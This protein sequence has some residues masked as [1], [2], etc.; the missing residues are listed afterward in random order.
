MKANH[1]RRTKMHDESIFHR[2]LEK[3]T[4]QRAAFLDEA[5]HGDAELRRRVERLLAEHERPDRHIL[6]APPAGFNA[7][8]YRSRPSPWIGKVIGHY[9]LHQEIGAGGMGIVL[10]AEQTQPLQRMVALK[11]IKPGMDTAQVIARFEA[12]RQALAMM[13]HP[14]IAKVL[15]AGTTDNGQPYFVMELVK[16]VPITTYCDEQHLPLRKRLELFVQVCQAIQHAHHKGIIH[17]DLKPTNVLVAEYDDRAVPKV[18]DFGVAKATAQ[19]LTER[20]MFTEFGQL[21]GTF[22]YMSPEQAKLNQLDVDTRS[23]IYSL[24]VLLYEL[25]AGSTP[26][27]R[28]RLR[29]AAFDEIL[30]IIREEEP[31]KPSTRLSTTDQLPTIAANRGL[32]PKKLSG[33]VKR[34]LDWIVMKSLE[35]D[36]TRRY[37]TASSF[38]EDIQRYLVGEA[39]AAHPPGTLYRLRK[40]LVKRRR[41]VAVAGLILFALLAGVAGIVLGL[42][43]ANRETAQKLAAEQQALSALRSKSEAETL[44]S[45]I[46]QN[47]L[48]NE[49][50][51]RP[52]WPAG[53]IALAAKLG[54]THREPLAQALVSEALAG[55]DANCVKDFSPLAAEYCAWNLTGEQLAIGGGSGGDIRIWNRLTNEE[56]SLRGVGPIEFDAD[57]LPVQLRRCSQD[58][59]AAYELVDLGSGKVRHRLELPADEAGNIG[60]LYLARRARYVVV[61]GESIASK[62]TPSPCD[63]P[64]PAGHTFIWDGH[65]GALLHKLPRSLNCVAVSPDGK[66]LAGGDGD[67]H[68]TLWDLD[69]GAELASLQ[70]D[71]LPIR[72]LAFARDYFAPQAH[73]HGHPRWLLAAGDSGGNV[74]IWDLALQIPRSVCSGGHYDILALDFFPDSSLL[75]SGGRHEAKIWDV[76]SGRELFALPAADF[77]LQT[78]FSPRGHLA[79]CGL[80]HPARATVWNLDLGRGIKLLRGLRGQ[81]AKMAFSPDQTYVA[82]LTHDWTIGVWTTDGRLK[83]A[84]RAPRGQT[85]DNAALA[86][87]PNQ[88]QLAYAAGTSAVLYDLRT[89]TVARHWD[90]P[91]GLV[92]VMAFPAADKLLLYRFESAGILRNL[93]AENPVIASTGASPLGE[94]RPYSA[95]ISAD[96]ERLVID[97]LQLNKDRKRMVGVFDAVGQMCYQVPTTMTAPFASVGFDPQGKVLAVRVHHDESTAL[98]DA[99]DGRSR[100]ALKKFPSPLGPDQQLWVRRRQEDPACPGFDLLRVHPPEQPIPF[101]V[102]L[103]GS[104]AMCFSRDGKLL[105]WGNPDGAV[106]LCEIAAVQRELSK[107]GFE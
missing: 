50:S 24:G 72:S 36:R 30:R 68:I 6:D 74:A 5:C 84:I 101:R 42:A 71:R 32:E 70:R 91:A 104:M 95:A 67:G 61:S 4:G 26:I 90:L 100:G 10:M 60:A 16:G 88:E 85:A 79:L 82:A 63:E 43:R 29:D 54:R 18:I 15:D 27:L 23:D 8:E 3:P 103:A 38:A 62:A 106:S 48:E 86:F 21:L 65:T 102:E 44:N 9:K 75:L 97:G 2:A 77:T 51:R 31:Q 73:A 49:S 34:E 7:T 80:G 20:T 22:E 92:D 56:T 12:E 78:R 52:G 1:G 55:L 76:A 37:G 83:H 98:F 94:L 81:I 99:R 40:L 39:V 105:A 57:D 53:T 96:G 14:N 25:L 66:Q 35:K 19:R 69:S 17:R 64:P 59:A 11:I 107:L 28:N 46:L 13:D 41:L 33:L 45:A 87:S 58:K 93:L 89:G 47:R